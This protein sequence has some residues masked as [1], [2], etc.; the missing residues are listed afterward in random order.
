MI[1][2]SQLVGYPSQYPDV[3][4]LDWN[5]GNGNARYWALKLLISSYGTATKHAYSTVSSR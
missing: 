2:E 5:T 1:G 4:M 3:T